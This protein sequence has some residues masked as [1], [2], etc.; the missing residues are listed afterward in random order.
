M[1]ATP[2]SSL[3]IADCRFKLVLAGGAHVGKTSIVHRLLDKPYNQAHEPTAAFDVTYLPCG[4]RIGSS[5]LLEL[6]AVAGAQLTAVPSHRALIA[7]DAAAGIY[8]M[9]LSDTA[10]A[11][12]CSLACSTHAL[13]ARQHSVLADC[14]QA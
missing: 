3:L 5:V 6:W 7:A 14:T 4:T 12:S 1:P 11:C 8:V 10:S 2:E 13:S 9:D